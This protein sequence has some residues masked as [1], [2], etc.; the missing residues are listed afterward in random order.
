MIYVVMRVNPCMARYKSATDIIGPLSAI[1]IFRIKKKTRGTLK[2][3][4]DRETTRNVGIW[5]SLVSY[6][7]TVSSSAS[8]LL[9]RGVLIKESTCKEKQVKF[10]WDQRDSRV[11]LTAVFD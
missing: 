3:K 2:Q 11:S 7:D 5:S 4:R 6:R 9:Q 10:S 1:L 8:Y